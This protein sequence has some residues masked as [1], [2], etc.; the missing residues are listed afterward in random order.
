MDASAMSSRTRSLLQCL[1]LIDLNWRRPL[2][3]TRVEARPL[4][5]RCIPS[6]IISTSP[7]I[8]EPAIINP[9]FGPSSSKGSSSWGGVTAVTLMLAAPRKDEAAGALPTLLVREAWTPDADT[10]LGTFTMIVIKTLA[11]VKVTTT[12]DASMPTRLSATS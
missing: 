5:D 10:P 2:P 12:S 6:K 7:P 1:V 3:P 8:K 9:T 4:P 11:A